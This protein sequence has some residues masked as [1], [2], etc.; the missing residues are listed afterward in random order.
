MEKIKINDNRIKIKFICE[1]DE[2]IKSRR[3]FL[4][5][6]KTLSTGNIIFLII[7][8]IIEIFFLAIHEFFFS[9]IIGVLLIISYVMVYILYF[10]QPGKLYDKTDFI[11]KEMLFEFSEKEILATINKKTGK[12]NWNIIKEIWESEEFI[13]LMQSNISYTLI[14][15]RAFKENGDTLSLRKMYINA[16]PNGKYK[17][18]K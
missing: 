15:K 14:P 6:S 8:T 18:I 10:L 5:E 4:R 12:T 2:Y 3:K 13:F 16:N 11:K 7:M 1:K 17:N 9:I